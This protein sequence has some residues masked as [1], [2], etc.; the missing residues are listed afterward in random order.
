M[1]PIRT[2]NVERVPIG[3][4]D[5]ETKKKNLIVSLI[6]S[7]LA[8]LIAPQVRTYIDTY[9]PV[10]CKVLRVTPPSRTLTALSCFSLESGHTPI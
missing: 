10:G 6:I 9:T 3:K 8:Q 5:D 1:F 2:I 4:K 7:H